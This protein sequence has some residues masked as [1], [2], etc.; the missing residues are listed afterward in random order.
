M[1]SKTALR[2]VHNNVKN[3][4]QSSSYVR[5]NYNLRK[6]TRLSKFRRLNVNVSKSEH[7]TTSKTVTIKESINPI[8][9]FTRNRS[10]SNLPQSVAAVST[11]QQPP[12]ANPKSYN[13]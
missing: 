7:S 1:A 4:I 13:L 8:A 3:F 12:K 11:V 9:S 6:S 5:R 2:V 10:S